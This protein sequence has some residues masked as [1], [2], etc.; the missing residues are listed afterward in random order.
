[1]LPIPTGSGAVRLTPKFPHH[2]V[3][4]EGQEVFTTTGIYNDGANLFDNVE[5]RI[6]PYNQGRFLDVTFVLPPSTNVNPGTTPN[7]VPP[8]GAGDA[9]GYG[10]FGGGGFNDCYSPCYDPCYDPCWD[11][12]YDPCYPPVPPCDPCCCDDKPEQGRSLL[13]RFER[14][15]DPTG[16]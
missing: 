15:E 12:C 14:L 11:P 16:K 6:L 4:V 9:G 8:T 3:K 13:Y 10:G 1:S 5:L 7:P 2:L